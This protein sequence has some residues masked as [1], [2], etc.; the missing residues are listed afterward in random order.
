LSNF[1]MAFNDLIAIGLTIMILSLAAGFTVGGYIIFLAIAWW[2]Y[3]LFA[4][5]NTGGRIA[6]G[7]LLAVSLYESYFLNLWL[8]AFCES[9]FI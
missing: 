5:H 3:F 8:R 1:S 2:I 7:I 6:I 9:L 4:Y